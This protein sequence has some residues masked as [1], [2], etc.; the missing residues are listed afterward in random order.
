MGTA[1]ATGLPNAGWRAL[2]AHRGIHEVLYAARLHNNEPGKMY[3]D[4]QVI[5][6]RTINAA[7][8]MYTVFTLI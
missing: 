3:K 2:H 6:D 5:E 7:K 4:V 1:P 8:P